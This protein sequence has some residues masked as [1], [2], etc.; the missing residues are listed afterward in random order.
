MGNKNPD[1]QFVV[2]DHSR[3]CEELGGST[4]I[5]PI[6]LLYKIEQKKAGMKYFMPASY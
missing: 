4:A 6:T 3:N 5:L 2:D 1:I